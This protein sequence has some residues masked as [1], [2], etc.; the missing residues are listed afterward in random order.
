ML[1]GVMMPVYK[2]LFK[3]RQADHKF[4]ASLD[5]KVRSCRKCKNKLMLR[6]NR[7][8]LWKSFFLVQD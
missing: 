4:N 1:V 8:N 6:G 2:S 5:F 3:M 7:S